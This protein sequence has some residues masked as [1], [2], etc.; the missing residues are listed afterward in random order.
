MKIFLVSFPSDVSTLSRITNKGK[1]DI[2]LSYFFILEEK[3]VL[4]E[5]MRKWG[6][7]EDENK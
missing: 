1:N 4:K 7:L 3:V 6:V 5:I 2:L